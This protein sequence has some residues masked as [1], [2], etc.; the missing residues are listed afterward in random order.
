MLRIHVEMTVLNSGMIW[1]TKTFFGVVVRI[2]VYSEL[3]FYFQTILSSPV[4]RC[5][6]I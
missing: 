3:P 4:S 1:A 6:L 2:T 5:R